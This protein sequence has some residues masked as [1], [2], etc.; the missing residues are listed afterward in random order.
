MKNEAPKT[1]GCLELFLFCR[2]FEPGAVRSASR[3]ASLAVN[4]S[5]NSRPWK[6]PIFRAALKEELIR[7]ER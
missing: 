7:H 1:A 6:S 3:L 5:W 4:R 2:G